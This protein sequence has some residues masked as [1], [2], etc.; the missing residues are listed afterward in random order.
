VA[1]YINSRRMENSAAT[2]RAR[3]EQALQQAFAPEQLIVRDDSQQHAGHAGWRE[4]G[5]THMHI[6]IVAEQFSGMSRLARQRAI[7]AVLIDFFA[8]GLHALSIDANC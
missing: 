4:G 3:I 8:E 7:N 6:I 5:G 2:R 1:D